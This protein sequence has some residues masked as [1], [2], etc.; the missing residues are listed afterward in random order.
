MAEQ[1]LLP[2]SRVQ[3]NEAQQQLLLRA[4][5]FLLCEAYPTCAGKQLFLVPNRSSC[6]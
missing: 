5:P 3:S 2:S 4:V 1:D 6:A